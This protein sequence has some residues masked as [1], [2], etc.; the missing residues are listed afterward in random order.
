MIQ[1]PSCS[2]S[3]PEGEFC[4]ACGAH[5]T[6]GSANRTHAFA[7]HPGEHVLHPGVVSTLFPHLPHRHAGPFRLALLAGTVLIAVLGM[8]G[9][10]A[11]DIAVACLVVPMLYLI[12]LY[13]AEVYED[14]PELV[15]GLTFVL[16]LAIAIPWTWFTGPFI[17]STVVQN[18]ISG[19]TFW[20]DFTA[21]ALIPL[22][23]Q[24]LM[25]AGPLAL[26]RRHYD[27]ALDG[28]AFGAAC[29]LGFTL[30][31]NLV[32]LWP[33][34]GQGLTSSHPTLDSTLAILGR[35]LLVPFI[36]ASTTGILAGALWLRRGKVRAPKAHGWT[37]T[38]PVVA[39]AVVVFWVFLGFVN[40]LVTSIDVA[41]AIYA[42]T[43][44]V[45]LLA[46]RIA[47]HHM[48]LAEAVEV[49][50]GPED[51]CRHCHYNVPRM[52]FCPHC[53]V[54]TRATPKHGSGR[55]LRVFR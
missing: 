24:A 5:L 29:A 3:V 36:A 11:A 55:L 38:V 39:A 21:G 15:I 30:A 20:R 28:F 35:G 9:L 48:L 13:E 50:V 4:G 42:V 26:Y 17:T 41:V 53:G 44:L 37:T 19:A 8:L 31:V 2:R 7:A 51:V 14:E 12:Y 18:G 27:E 6:T 34:L 16:G 1:C 46:V 43:A 45:L 33:D 22:G 52:A 47:L 23:A 10:T 32:D 25:L 40:I 49:T 54:A